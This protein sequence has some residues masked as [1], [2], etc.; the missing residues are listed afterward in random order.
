MSDYVS[1]ADRGAKWLDGIVPGWHNHVNPDTLDIA[2]WARCV[3]G[4]LRAV[5][6]I[7]GEIPPP[8]PTEA[9]DGM[10]GWRNN[11]FMCL[12]SQRQS[13]DPGGLNSRWREL[14]YQRRTST[15]RL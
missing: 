5:G 2:N 3:F 6:V 14:I 4:Q 15:S 12:R 13:Q 10:D 11:G 9:S 8:E 1:P 7:E